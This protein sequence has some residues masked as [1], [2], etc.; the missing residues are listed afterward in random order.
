MYRA[1]SLKIAE[2]V[3]DEYLEY[4][5]VVKIENNDAAKSGLDA[6]FDGDGSLFATKIMDNW[7]PKV[8]ADVFLSHSHKDENLAIGLAGWLK[9]KFDISSFIDSC[10]WGYSDEL[11]KKLDKRFCLQNDG[12][13][14]YSKRNITTSHVNMMLATSLTKMIDQCEC[15]IFLNTPQ[16][17]S[18]KGCIEKDGTESPWIYAEIDATRM[19]RE[20]IPERKKILY[21]SQASVESRS[22]GIEEAISIKYDLDLKH[23]LH[24]EEKHILR[25]DGCGKKG[26]EA[27]DFLYENI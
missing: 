5:K 16:S 7:F 11:L 10:V 17:I 21:K 20:N 3:F 18:C 1:F 24:L 2:H 22:L 19:L 15:I 13:Y 26:E 9:D 12:Y 14:S 6:F 27:L 8:K 4:G 25:W 23:L